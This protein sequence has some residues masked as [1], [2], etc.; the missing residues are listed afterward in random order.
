MYTHTRTQ[1]QTHTHR[2]IHKHTKAHFG[3]ISRRTKIKGNVNP[4]AYIFYCGTL[5]SSFLVFFTTTSRDTLW[6]DDFRKPE[7]VFS[8]AVRSSIE[9]EPRDSSKKGRSRESRESRGATIAS[10]SPKKSRRKSIGRKYS[11]ARIQK[12][13]SNYSR[14]PETNPRTNPTAPELRIARVE[15]TTRA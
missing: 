7:R 1:T 4:A 14:P 13:P 10:R 5:S 2:Q 6:T 8:N 12:E 9:A 15:K 3:R 11:T